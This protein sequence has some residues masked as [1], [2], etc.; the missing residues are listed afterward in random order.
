[1]RKGILILS[2]I[3]R[4]RCRSQLGLLRAREPVCTTQAQARH[5][6]ARPCMAFPPCSAKAQV[7]NQSGAH[8]PDIMGESSFSSSAIDHW[9][10]MLRRSG[11]SAGNEDMLAVFMADSG[12]LNNTH[13]QMADHPRGWPGAECFEEAEL[14]AI[15]ALKE[16]RPE[17]SR[18]LLVCKARRLTCMLF[19]CLGAGRQ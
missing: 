13:L 19:C 12:V 2:H 8:V 15:W 9:C 5:V 7:P 4:S 16:F 14:N 3:P 10:S 1:M 17:R 6:R 11:Y 18:W